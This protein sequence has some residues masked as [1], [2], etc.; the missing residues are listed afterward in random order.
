MMPGFNPAACPL[1]GGA[2][3]CQLCS[4]VVYKGQC[5]CAR[6]EIPGE[7]LA[8]VPEHLQNRACICR[9]CIVNFRAGKDSFAPRPSHRSPGFTLIEL[10][11]VIGIIA[12]IAAMLLPVLNNARGTAKSADC[13]S[14]LRQMGFAAQLYWDDYKGNSFGY[15]FGATNSG[16]IYWFG[17]LGTGSAGAEPFDL[18]R[19]ALYPYLHGSDVRLCPAFTTQMAAFRLKGSSIIFSYGDNPYLFGSPYQNPVS[20]TKILH[21]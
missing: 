3:E 9:A 13:D 19:G 17:W 12:I 8:R 20:A 14:N 15:I 16:V 1:C 2:N 21:P 10:L 7:L 4:A 5:W 6:E 18:S 11:V